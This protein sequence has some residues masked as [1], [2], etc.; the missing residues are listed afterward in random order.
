MALHIQDTGPA[1]TRN[2]PDSAIV[3]L[4][5]QR[6]EGAILASQHKYGRYCH[7]V[8]ERILQN[9][10]DAE[11]CVNDTWLRAWSAMPPARPTRLQGF[12]GAITRHLA[13]DRLNYARAQKR[14][15]PS[16]CLAEVTDEFWACLPSN[17][18]SIADEA[19]FRDLL[20]RFLGALDARTRVVFLQRYFYACS[21]RDIAERAG[22]SE[23]A[24]KLLLYRTRTKLKKFLEKEGISV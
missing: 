17:E 1:D 18:A 5:H 12:L 10:E 21:V 2:L 15:G 9:R 3:D 13:L 20:N 16:S 22:M 19:A 4:Y 11:E 24:V 7:A 14:G 23:G 8:A 6:D